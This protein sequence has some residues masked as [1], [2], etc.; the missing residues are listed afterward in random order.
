MNVERYSAEDLY[1]DLY[2]GGWH[3][4]IKRVE[5]WL[6]AHDK[7]VLEKAAQRVA[8]LPLVRVMWQPNREEVLAAV[9][10]EGESN[11]DA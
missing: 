2:L 8:Y 1:R 4:T 3:L 11:A 9:R 5:E 7:E 10:G 6:A